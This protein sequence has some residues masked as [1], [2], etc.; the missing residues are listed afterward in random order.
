MERALKTIQSKIHETNNVVQK[1]NAEVKSQ[2]QQ[3]NTSVM[4]AH[5]E[6]MQFRQEAARFPELVERAHARQGLEDAF[7]LA[8]TTSLKLHCSGC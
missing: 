1:S 7:R 4:H 3:T 8:P 5:K 2:I 6:V